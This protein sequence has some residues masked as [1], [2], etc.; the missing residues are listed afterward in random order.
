MKYQPTEAYF[1]T[2][3]NIRNFI[4][5]N[6]N[7]L[8]KPMLKYFV[9][10]A[11]IGALFSLIP[12]PIVSNIMLI[13]TPL[14][15]MYFGICLAIT[16]H[17]FFMD[18]PEDYVAFNPLKPTKHALKYIL[19]ALGLAIVLFLVTAAVS[20]LVFYILGV[21]ANNGILSMIMMVPIFIAAVYIGYRFTFIYPSIALGHKKTL[22]ECWTLTKGY[23]GKMML[24]PFI[25][26]Y[27]YLLLA[28]VLIILSAGMSFI[29]FIGG[30]AKIIITAAFDAFLTPVFTIF[31]AAVL[32]N[33]YILVW[34]KEN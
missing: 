28:I 18:G 6:F 7:V 16:T 3:R 5:E 20:A 17:R 24:V 30:V 15:L 34:N 21:I 11:I 32:S 9:G 23:V 25:A 13:I 2:G 10:C 26:S 33:Y 12:I 19:F 4:A 1:E 14:A 29:P 8:Y 31:W 22:K 27:K